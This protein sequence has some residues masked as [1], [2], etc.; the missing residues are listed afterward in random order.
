MGKHGPFD[1]LSPSTLE[2]LEDDLKALL[3]VT[4]LDKQTIEAFQALRDF[5]ADPM[6]KMD[7]EGKVYWLVNRFPMIQ[8]RQM[9]KG[10]GV[11]ERVIHR[12]LARRR[13]QIE[14]SSAWRR[15]PSGEALGE[16]EVSRGG[17]DSHTRGR[18]CPLLQAV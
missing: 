6:L 13:S 7:L 16:P 9:A 12:Y 2:W 18:D 17:I 4:A 3:S 10:L 8:V 15:L 5:E 1:V 11:S 14:R